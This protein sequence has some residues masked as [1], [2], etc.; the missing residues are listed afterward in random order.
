V[1]GATHLTCTDDAVVVPAASA[2]LTVPPV[3]SQLAEQ[4]TQ[5]STSPCVTLNDLL[6]QFRNHYSFN[7]QAPSGS[8]AAVLDNFAQ[9]SKAEGG[10]TGTSE[11][12]AA[13]FALMAASLDMNVRVVVGFFPRETGPGNYVSG[14]RDATAWVE[15]QF[16]HEGWVPFFPNSRKGGVPA[17]ER[18]DEHKSVLKS[19]PPGQSPSGAGPHRGP[20]HEGFIPS[21]PPSGAIGVLVLVVSI[22]IAVLLLVLV[23]VALLVATTQ[24]RR[25]R[26][27]RS[28]R[29]PR[30][31][32]MG[33]WEESLDCLE[34]VGIR[35]SSTDTAL[36][37]ANAGADRLGPPA[38]SALTSL[39]GLS[40]GARF[41]TET[42]DRPDVDR[43]WECAAQLGTVVHESL[44][45]WG[46]IRRAF[47]LRIVFVAGRHVKRR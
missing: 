6:A 11:Q 33:A 38:L 5:G 43:A 10:G 46:R 18:S 31:G 35:V 17:A 16:Q 25:R 20:A 13:A 9:G 29:D 22:V 26:R 1:S 8:S 15:V 34:S 44:G 19:T 7:A 37:V 42:I 21:P 4:Y 2:T 30:L 41:S 32:V 36:E 27:R 24:R 45:F 40:N 3:L 39:G 14:P 47:N 23:A 28:L 12:F